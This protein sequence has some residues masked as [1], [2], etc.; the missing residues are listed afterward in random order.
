MSQISHLKKCQRNYI[1]L[2]YTYLGNHY[3]IV[4]HFAVVRLGVAILC[5]GRRP[6]LFA[7]LSLKK[8]TYNSP[9]RR[10]FKKRVVAHAQTETRAGR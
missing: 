10:H 2:V 9:R 5:D 8:A 1:K 3:H 7:T 4:V 6:A